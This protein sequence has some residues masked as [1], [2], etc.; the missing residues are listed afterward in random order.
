MLVNGKCE[1]FVM[2]MLYACVLCVSCSS[3]QCCV[4]HDLLFVNAGRE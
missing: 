2:L 4:L 1:Y 3:F